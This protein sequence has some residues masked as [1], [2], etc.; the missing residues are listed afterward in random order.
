MKR[1]SVNDYFNESNRWLKRITGEEKYKRKRDIALISKE[2][3]D[4]KYY[5]LLKLNYDSIEDYKQKEFENAGL[6]QDTLLNISLKDE[7]FSTKLSIARQIFYSLIKDKIFQYKSLNNCELG[8]GYGFNL[9][10]FPQYTYGGE[11]SKNAVKLGKKLGLDIKEFNYYEKKDYKILKNNTTVVTVHSLEQ[12]PDSNIFVENLKSHKDKINYVINFEPSYIHER[13]NFI[14]FCRNRYIQLNDYNR[15]LFTE[16]LSRT[17][18]EVIEYEYDIFGLNPLNST[19]LI[20]W[21][22]K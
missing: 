6:L 8:C 15:N 18:V 20:V 16:L 7:I 19:N 14:G 21:R 2:Y 3:D 9:T 22:F 12:I 1:I 10:Y 4:T 5:D 13:K 17:D 11:F